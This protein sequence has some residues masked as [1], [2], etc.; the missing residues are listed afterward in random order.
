MEIN[1]KEAL[2]ENN[3]SI[4]NE[5]NQLKVLI[6][7]SNNLKEKILK[8]IEAINKIY[9]DQNNEITIS[10]KKKHED[11]TNKEN[12]LK[13]A[14]KNEVTKMKEKLEEYYSETN[15]EI[16]EGERLNKIINSFEK[17]E[18]GKSLIK[19][20]TYIS[21]INKKKK[22]IEKLLLKLMKNLK[23]TYKEDEEILKLD[24]YHFSGIKNPKDIE[25]ND[26]KIDSLKM[27]WKF[28]ENI[29]IELDMKK[30][31]YKV[32]MRK[33]NTKDNFIQV[34]EGKNN[35]C[36]IEK[37]NLGTNYEFRICSIYEDSISDWTPLQNV[38]TL[39]I[40][41]KI[42][43]ETNRYNEFLEK[44]FE[45]SGFKTMELI[46]RGTRD[47]TTSQ[48]FHEKC[49]NQGPTICLYKNDKG[50]VF[51][52]YAS[53]SW[54]T[55]S[56]G[57][58]RAPDC[59]IFT[60]TNIHETEPTRF[61]FKGSSDS[62]YH[63]SS[64]GAHFGGDIKIFED[65]NSEDSRSQFPDD[66]EDSLGKGKSIFTGDLNNNNYDFRVKEIEVFKLFK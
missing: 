11:L 12:D 17:D 5:K 28:E 1:E 13:D 8:E 48:K 33:E 9:E 3:I 45:W 29:P 61:K 58:Y 30:L 42:L 39:S 64:H 25:F 26:I 10:F 7:E 31:K 14:L 37:L 4:E 60:L 44:I 50:Y 52:G 15:K 16:K 66:Y 54:S 40:D 49:D 24:E 57:Y 34:Y 21:Y 36:L 65:F 35:N 18:E 2:K 6:Q 63:G 46:Y 51:G 56:N 38:K 20:L 19:E 32:E 27:S 23:I 41:S 59:F 62:V 47:G 53:V 43:M 55:Y 22:E